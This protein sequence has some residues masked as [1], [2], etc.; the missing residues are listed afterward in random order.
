[1]H[2]ETAVLGEVVISEKGSRKIIEGL[3]LNN[4]GQLKGKKRKRKKEKKMK[5]KKEKENGS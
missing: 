5:K 3:R 1:M 4:K 2:L